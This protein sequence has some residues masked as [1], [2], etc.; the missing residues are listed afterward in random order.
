M[1][2]SNK[3]SMALRYLRLSVIFQDIISCPDDDKL[4]A[5]VGWVGK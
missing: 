5:L 4:V 2:R 1:K 3:L